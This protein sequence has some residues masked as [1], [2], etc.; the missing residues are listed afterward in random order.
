MKHSTLALFLAVSC[1]CTTVSAATLDALE[2]G[3]YRLDPDGY[4]EPPTTSPNGTGRTY[5]DKFG[6]AL[7]TSARITYA[8]V[9]RDPSDT[10]NRVLFLVDSQYHYDINSPN[11]LCPA[12]AFPDWNDM[13]EQEPF[14]RTNIGDRS[15]ARFDWATDAFTVSWDSDIRYLGPVQENKDKLL[16]RY[17]VTHRG[18]RFKLETP[19]PYQNV[20]YLLKD[21]PFF[22]SASRDTSLGVLQQ[23][24]YV[25][26]ITSDSEWEEV[27]HYAP[28]GSATHGWINRDDLKDLNWVDQQDQTEQFRFRVGFEPDEAHAVPLAIDVIDRATGKRVQVMRDFYSETLWATEVHSALTLVDANF[29]G[30][31]DLMILGSNG[32]AGPNSTYNFFLFDK[33]SRRFVFNEALSE[34]SQIQIDAQMKEITS[35]QR[36]GCCSHS[37][38]TFRYINGRLVEVAN[39]DESMTADGEW[40]ETTVGRLHKGKMQY[41]TTRRPADWE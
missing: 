26:V 18:D 38:Q 41:Q 2:P 29:D 20:Q 8:I 6:S 28:D 30:D 14:C 1:F 16:L 40:I 21:V 15:E 32:G 17:E 12:Y 10:Q 13:S 36:N 22:A 24:G 3:I 4:H 27:D 39:R 37:S 9:S 35:A 11:K 5:E 34:L 33:Q 25:A 31:Q 19:R 23:G 7:P